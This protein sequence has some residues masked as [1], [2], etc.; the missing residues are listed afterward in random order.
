MRG[1]TPRDLLVV[2]L[3]WLYQNLIP[4]RIRHRRY[5]TCPPIDQRHVLPAQRAHASSAPAAHVTR[6]DGDRNMSVKNDDT[7]D[8]WF[9]VG[10][11]HEPNLVAQLLRT[12]VD[13]N[14]D[15]VNQH[16]QTV[17]GIVSIITEHKY[18]VDSTGLVIGQVDVRTRLV[19]RAFRETDGNGHPLSIEP[20]TVQDDPQEGSVSEYADLRFVTRDSDSDTPSTQVPSA[21]T[22]EV[23]REMSMARAHLIELFTGE[24]L[25]RSTFDSHAV[26][27]TV[28]YDV[29]HHWCSDRRVPDEYRLTFIDF[30]NHLTMLGYPRSESP[31]RVLPEG[32]E[33]VIERC[34]LTR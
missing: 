16:W 11:R 9:V 26:R 10:E 18:R 7:Y 32:L 8:T 17:P 20:F 21:E 22:R 3:L 30:I 24:C 31:R 6:E 23:A 2:A 4:E 33:Y 27:L 13:G 25:A 34:T 1:D 19:V 5:C 14:D 15:V 28:V 29:Y 12:Q